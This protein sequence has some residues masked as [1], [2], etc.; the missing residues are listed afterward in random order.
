MSLTVISLFCLSGLLPLALA[1]SQDRKPDVVKKVA[2]PFAPGSVRL[3][4]GPFFDAQERDREFLNKLE[5]DRLLHRFR[6]GAG[7]E[8]KGPIYG[9]WEMDTISGHSLGHYLSACAH[10][11]AA[12]DDEG[13]KEKVDHI[14]AELKVCQDARKDGYVGGI[15]N[16]DRLWDEIRKG[17]IRSQG[18]DLNGIWVPWYTQHK[19]FSGLLDCYEILG[20]KEA[21]AIADR[22]G[23]WAVEVTSNL[24]P[25]KWQRMMACEFGGMNEAMA[26][27]YAATGK[28][29]HLELAR[30]FRHEAVVGPLERGEPKI[31]GHHG[32]TQIPKV[33]GSA[34]LYELRGE[35]KDE[36]ASRFFWEQVVRDHTYA[37]GGHGMNEYFGP[38]DRLNERLNSS[39]AET[40]NTYNM[41]KLTRM[42]MSWGPTVEQG[43]FYERAMLNHILASQDPRSGGMIYF[44]PL[45]AGSFKTYSNVENSFWCCTG[46]GMEN[47]ARYG[48]AIFFD[49]GE[50]LLV[51]LFVASELDWKAKGLKVKL[52]T[53]YPIDG[54]VR[55]TFSGSGK[56]AGLRIRKPAWAAGDFGLK[57]N[58]SGIHVMADAD[59]FLALPRELKG[60]DVVEF[61][62]P[63]RLRT[64]AMP[65]NPD[66]V[67]ILWGPAVLS[68]DLGSTRNQVA[69]NEFPVLITGDRDPA[70]WLKRTSED[71]IE[72]TCSAARPGPVT[73]R[74][75]YNLHHRRA[76][77]YFDYFTEAQ[78]SQREEDYRKEQERLRVLEA[79]TTDH[80]RIGEMQPE[81][82]HNLQG[83]NTR[84]GDFNN[85][86]WRH[87]NR[88]GWFSFE[89]KVDSA[90]EH[91]L[92]LTFW[93]GDSGGREFQVL[94]DG[95]VLMEIALTGKHPG[96]FFDEVLKVP[97]EWTRGKT[98]V[99]VKLQA[100]PEMTAGGLFDARML[101]VGNDR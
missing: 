72:F 82:D 68:G 74:P 88:G 53:R 38:P 90:A 9:G 43:D 13:L 6:I 76:I 4:P 97:R 44:A 48:E 34:R 46:T 15:P 37:I 73:L 81:R 99:T 75:Y 47:H 66:R 65:D 59:G 85:R 11:I 20:K 54:L 25:E 93:G 18:F 2:L 45:Q 22:L 26:N 23:D 67:A 96:R 51:N 3:L 79:R 60:D 31:Q 50:T 52:E 32:N 12:T 86:K 77:T 33:L 55:L 27:L 24:T 1:S 84:A 95:Q 14:L 101:K 10:M 42:L 80:L 58:G 30:K 64:E 8:P 98:K 35:A 21:L 69:P 89:M 92:L 17:E 19:L 57:L 78:W 83:E 62:V 5:P 56:A 61:T 70:N 63:L 71:R 100:K 94:V 36:K 91:E 39:T 7:L 49:E 29:A 41:L 40:C 87:A 16:P 28:P